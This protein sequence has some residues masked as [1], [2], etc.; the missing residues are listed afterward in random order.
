MKLKR[1]NKIKYKTEIYHISITS[2]FL[3]LSVALSLIELPKIPLPWGVYFDYRIFDT[4]CLFMAIRMAGLGYSLI[5]GSLTPWIHVLID[6]RHS[7]VSM[8]AFMLNNILCIIIFWF[9]YYK[10]FKAD[11][12]LNIENEKVEPDASDPLNNIVTH[13]HNFKKPHISKKISAFSIITILC[14]LC[15]S[16]SYVAVFALMTSGIS[17]PKGDD[18]QISSLNQFFYGINILW[19]ILFFMAIF[20]IKYI[21]ECIIIS[22]LEKR[23]LII[24]EHYN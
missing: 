10:L 2:I 13:Q 8:A 1:K 4:L 17:K 16:L 15:E 14:S 5:V 22:L 12:K 11:L 18:T 20:M 24:A 7:M 6:G 9:F 19:T 23:F 3:A 21:V